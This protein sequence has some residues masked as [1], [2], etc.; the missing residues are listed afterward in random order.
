MTAVVRVCFTSLCALFCTQAV[1][2]A[3]PEHSVSVSRQFLVYGADL[4]LRGVICDL[5]ER[6]KRDV[7][8]RIDQ[9]DEWATPIV[10]NAQY[11]QVNWPEKPPTAFVFSQTGSG[12]KLQLDLT[13]AQDVGQPEVRR[14]L[15]RAILLEMMYRGRTDLP[16]GATYVLPPDWLLAGISPPQADIESERWADLLRVQVTAQ[17]VLPLAEILSQ[18][19]DQLDESGRALHRAYSLALV[20]FLS[21]TTEARLRLARFVADLPAASNDPMADLGR[22]FPIFHDAKVAEKAWSC[23][24]AERTAVGSFQWLSWEE[25]NQKL[26]EILVVGIPVAG[27]EKKYQLAEFPKFIGAASARIA[28][29]RRSREMSILSTRVNPLCRP[30]L[31]EYARIAMLLARG[32][33]RGMAE[34]LVR[35]SASRRNI[36]ARIGEID[37]YMNW[38]EAA[39]SQEMSGVFDGYGKAAEAA[40]QPRSRR[41]DAISVYVD[42]LEAEFQN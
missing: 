22:H 38:F 42:V 19:H 20:E 36:S 29:A 23:H 32:K 10:I 18:R 25:A 1:G 11:P 33:T 40:A 28:L 16:P 5:A 34:R 3:L 35:L 13:I 21:A 6:T 12:L 8:G 39:K 17:E 7:L 24:L 9:R 14:E 41:R 27:V 4:R 26:D 30:I 2:L 37:D 15:L 31:R